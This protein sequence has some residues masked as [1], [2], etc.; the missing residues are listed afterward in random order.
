MR[1]IITN[2]LNKRLSKREFYYDITVEEQAYNE[3]QVRKVFEAICANIPAYLSITDGEIFKWNLNFDQA[4]LVSLDVL[5][6]FDNYD[7]AKKHLD[8]YEDQSYFDIPI[9]LLF[10]SLYDILREYNFPVSQYAFG[11]ITHT[12]KS[13]CPK[14]TKMTNT[15]FEIYHARFNSRVP[16]ALPIEKTKG[17]SFSKSQQNIDSARELFIHNVIKRLRSHAIQ[18]QVH[19]YIEA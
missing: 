10:I 11:N 5:K 14:G 2:L 6:K 16:I 13:Y 17:S 12:M 1:Q 15:V 19:E 3:S 18:N 9:N 7:I 4:T 8:I